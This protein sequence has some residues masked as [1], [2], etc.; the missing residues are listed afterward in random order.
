MLVLLGALLLALDM[1]SVLVLELKV[2]VLVVSTTAVSWLLRARLTPHDSLPSPLMI[3][4]LL[5][6]VLPVV[7]LVLRILVVVLRVVLVVLVVLVILVKLLGL[8]VPLVLFWWREAA[9]SWM[10]SSIVTFLQRAVNQRECV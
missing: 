4:L 8:L 7:L 3:L 2:H 5:V 6:L 1:L 10:Y 9:I